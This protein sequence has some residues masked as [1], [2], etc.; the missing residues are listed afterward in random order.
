MKKIIFSIMA[1]LFLF[2]A[3]EKQ[4][5]VVNSQ[6]AENG[7]HKVIP[8]DCAET[9][10]TPMIA[11]GGKYDEKCTG[12]E[13]GII[14]VTRTDL[15]NGNCTYDVSYDIT[16]A[17]WMIEE[18]HLYIGPEDGIPATGG[19]KKN[20]KIG[21]F[22]FND[23]HNPAVATYSYS[24]TIPCADDNVIAA[25]AVVGGYDGVI[26][27]CESLPETVDVN[28]TYPGTTGL[29]DIEIVGGPFAGIY[30]GWCIDATHNAVYTPLTQYQVFCSYGDLPTSIT[31]GSDPHLDNPELLPI[32]N[33]IVNQTIVGEPSGCDGDYT[34]AD[35][36][37]AIWSFI[38]DNPDFELEGAD[39]C[40]VNEIIAMIDAAGEEA[41]NFD[42]GNGG[43]MAVLLV[44]PGSA[45][46]LVAV[47]DFEAGDYGDE[48]AW[49][50]G[51]CGT[52][53]SVGDCHGGPD[54]AEGISFT[55]STTYYGG[56]AWG[57]YFYGCQPTQ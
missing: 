6:T 29:F 25:H 20:P 11:G 17:G 32:V 54:G 49:G 5:E 24:K 18:T 41:T 50:Y 15:G 56:N 4:E 31:T 55:E 39:T 27:Y 42:P 22:E 35:V 26:D 44:P 28:L 19:K 9:F 12:I 10:T 13:V 48:T 21:H 1:V 47:M 52:C 2:T 8:A 16:M 51:Y 37:V 38:D 53:G 7:F 23:E 43:V 34:A 57:W 45:Q 46:L 40:R 3:C 36:A 14:T 33:W 30:E